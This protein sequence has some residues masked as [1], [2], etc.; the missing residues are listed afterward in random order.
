[1]ELQPARPAVARPTNA[2]RHAHRESVLIEDPPQPLG[3]WRRPAA[4][5]K[6]HAVTPRRNLEQRMPLA[7]N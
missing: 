1:M 3:P 2:G 7:L 5:L 4:K 6:P